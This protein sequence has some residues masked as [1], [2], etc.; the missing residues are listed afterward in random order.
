MPLSI[1]FCKSSIVTHILGRA[2]L[3]VVHLEAR[4]AQ[5]EGRSP[6]DRSAIR[7]PSSGFIGHRRMQHLNGITQIL[8][9]W[10]PAY[11]P[12][13]SPFI[14]SMLVGAWGTNVCR[15]YDHDISDDRY[16]PNVSKM[17]TLALK[18]VSRYW[19]I[20]TLL[21]RESHLQSCASIQI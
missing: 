18:H 1:K 8:R 10:A 6:T 2:K 17:V 21:L 5:A 11:I 13:S 19:K 12:L 16:M 7:S 14:A 3:H 15:I 9:E 4:S 20:G